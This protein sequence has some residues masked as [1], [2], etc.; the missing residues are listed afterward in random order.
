MWINTID[1]QTPIEISTLFYIQN[2]KIDIYVKRV[3]VCV[4]YLEQPL[5]KLCEEIH[6]KIALINKNKIL[7]LFKK[8]TGKQE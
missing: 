3:C 7:K 2:I 4:Y 6:S 1:F 5:E 8:S